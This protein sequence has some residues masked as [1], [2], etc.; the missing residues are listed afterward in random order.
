MLWSIIL[1]FMNQDLIRLGKAR[2]N[3]SQHLE[4]KYRACL[5]TP[6]YH[7]QLNPYV[8]GSSAPDRRKY[9]LVCY[10]A[11][12]TLLGLVGLALLYQIIQL[13]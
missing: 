9:F 8:C 7:L 10:T 1:M 2:G 6:G 12:F 4:R 13:L 5:A 3:V 11:N